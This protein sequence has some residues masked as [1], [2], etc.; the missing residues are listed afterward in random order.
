[1]IAFDAQTSGGLLMSVPLQLVEPLINDL[2]MTGLTSS[3]VIGSV[4]EKGDKFLRLEN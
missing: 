2:H 4:M 1:M 3:A